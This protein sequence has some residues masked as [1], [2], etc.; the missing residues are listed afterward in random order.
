MCLGLPKTSRFALGEQRQRQGFA[1]GSS[2]L[3][4]WVQR[5]GFRWVLLVQRDLPAQ[6]VAVW[7]RTPG[8]RS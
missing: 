5:V 8:E 2:G 6:G 7:P 1:E 4:E 3:S